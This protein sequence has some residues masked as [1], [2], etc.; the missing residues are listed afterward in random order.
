MYPWVTERHVSVCR[1][2][3]DTTLV[4]GGAVIRLS[5]MAADLDEGVVQRFGSEGELSWGWALPE[6]LILLAGAVV[7]VNGAQRCTEPP[8]SNHRR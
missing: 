3:T 1:L 2:F 5:G 4:Q 6:T 7:L 8:Q